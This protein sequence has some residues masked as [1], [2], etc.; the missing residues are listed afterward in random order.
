MTQKFDDGLGK[1]IET[2]TTY[3][4]NDPATVDVLDNLKIVIAVSATSIAMIYTSIALA[5]C[6]FIA[7]L[8]AHAR[9]AEVH[10]ASDFFSTLVSR[11]ALREDDS[12]IGF[13]RLPLIMMVLATFFCTFAWAEYLG[14]M[15]RW[16]HVSPNPAFTVNNM[17]TFNWGDGLALLLATT[18]LT[19]V[20][21]FVLV[22][23]RAC[24]R[25]CGFKSFD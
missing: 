4:Y 14:G 6:A 11:D 18:V 22:P 25:C 20:A 16:L 2:T 3:W 23:P 1:V 19:S 17:G 21:C 10:N 8:V 7:M 15:E 24:L 12:W 9:H 13:P 5:I